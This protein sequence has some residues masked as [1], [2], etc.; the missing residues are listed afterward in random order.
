MKEKLLYL[1]VSG[2]IAAA[3]GAFW[4]V[5]KLKNQMGSIQPTVKGNKELLCL[6]AIKMNVAKEDLE[7]FCIRQEISK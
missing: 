6:I 4:D 1:V 7:K 3:S 5:Q 2:S